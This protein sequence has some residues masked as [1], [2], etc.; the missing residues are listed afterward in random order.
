MRFTRRG[1][2]L[3]AAASVALAA[4]GVRAASPDIIR[5][6]PPGYPLGEGPIWSARHKAV[7]FVDILSKELHRYDLDRRTV[8][9][10]WG[11]PDMIGWIV[12]RTNGGFVVGVKDTVYLLDLEPFKLTELCKIEADKP[13]N[14]LNDAK[15]DPKGRLWTGTMD[16]AFKDRTAALYRID[17]DHSVHVIDTNYVCTN[18]PAF[19][20]SG[21][22]M[23][24]NE[25]HDGIVYTYDIA[26]DGSASN[27]RVFAKFAEGVGLPDGCT[28][29]ADDGFWVAH[30]GGGRISRY[31]PDG[32]L[33]FDVMMPAKNIT[34]MTFCGPALDR[35]VVTSAAQQITGD[36]GEAGTLFEV[37][38]PLLRGHK[39][40]P[41]GLY[42][43]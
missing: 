19:S 32:T 9:Q 17:A 15:V 5:L 31:K 7:F 28:T 35:L 13:G 43:G 34:S 30:Y 21:E 40:L 38:K 41:M 8:V 27:R 12:E 18:G 4:T 1:F 24:H 10:S 2:G 33:D 25:T 23:Y 6:T 20:R 37:P 16:L 29:D 26:A 14:R 22:R 42:A 39:G 36:I 3:S 11:M